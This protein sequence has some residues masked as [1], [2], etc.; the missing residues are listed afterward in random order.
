MKTAVKRLAPAAILAARNSA[1]HIQI[2]AAANQSMRKKAMPVPKAAAT[3]GRGKLPPW[4][5]A[6]KD[7][8]PA[9][10][11]A[12]VIV[13]RAAAASGKGGVESKPGRALD[14]FDLICHI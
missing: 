11:H 3:C 5:W 9:G 4:F 10:S 6:M 2:T 13:C 8:A 14:P 12:K 1:F 7:K